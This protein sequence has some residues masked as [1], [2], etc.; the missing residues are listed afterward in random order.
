MSIIRAQSTCMFGFGYAAV[1]PAKRSAY[2]RLVSQSPNRMLLSSLE[3]P[4]V[5]D[6]WL[7]GKRFVEQPTVPIEVAIRKGYEHAELL[8]WFGTPQIMSD[9]FHATL[10]AAGVDNLDVYDA[11]R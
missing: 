5:D 4:S 11:A 10:V 8:D 9:R 6:S 2:Y 3:D 7:F 1:M